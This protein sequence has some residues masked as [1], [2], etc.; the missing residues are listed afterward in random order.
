MGL[1]VREVLERTR[2]ETLQIGGVNIPPWDTLANALNA[3]DLTFA[4]SGTRDVVVPRDSLLEFDDDTLELVLNRIT[5]GSSVSVYQRGYLESTPGTHAAGTRV[6]VNPPWP[7]IVLF[8]ALKG[9]IASL[10]S[11][12]IYRRNLDS[13]R[14]F[15]ATAP[16]VLNALDKDVATTIWFRTGNRWQKLRRG[17]EFEVIHETSPIEIQFWGFAQEGASL[18]ILTKRDFTQPTALTDDLDTLGIPSSLQPFMSLGIASMVLQGKE[19]PEVQAEHI[20][21]SLA[22]QDRPVGSRISV[23]SALWRAFLNQVALER[24]RLMEALPP[25]IVYERTG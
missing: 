7:Q 19:V 2:N 14:T 18:R 13:S 11:Y 24:S 16:V 21:R 22:N 5:S 3:T 23:A 17:T 20:R 15:T 4:L 8:N 25:A 12:G 10:Y 9:L 6:I 1:T